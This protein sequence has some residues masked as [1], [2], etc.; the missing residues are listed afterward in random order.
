MYFQD[1]TGKC[2]KNYFYFGQP[3][4][5]FKPLVFKKSK[6]IQPS[7]KYSLGGKGNGDKIKDGLSFGQI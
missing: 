5:L 4:S 6:E 7:S 3:L 2:L 1:L